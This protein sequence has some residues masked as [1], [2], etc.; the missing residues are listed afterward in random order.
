MNRLTLGKKTAE[1]NGNEFIG[2]VLASD[3]VNMMSLHYTFTN[4][5]LGDTLQE[6]LKSNF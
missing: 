5:K 1:K 3:R 4:S 6:E 2:A